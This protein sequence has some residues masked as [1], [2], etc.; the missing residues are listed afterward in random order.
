MRPLVAP[1]RLRNL[2]DAHAHKVSW[3]ELFFDLI[4]VAAVAQVA[5]PLHEHYTPDGVVRFALLFALVWWAWT[6]YAT[7]AT[8][9][10]A[11]DGLQRGLMVVQVFVVA[12]MAANAR[13]ALD[14]RSTAGFA[15]AYAVLRFILIAQYLRARR[16]VDAHTLS[17]RFAAGHGAAAVLWLV[18]AVAPM[19]S[20]FWLWGVAFIVDFGTPWMTIPA[21]VKIPPG[22]AHLPE[23]FGLFTL[24]LLGEAVVAVMRGMESQEAWPVSAAVSAVLSMVLLFSTWWWYFEGV[25]ASAARHIHSRADAVTLQLWSYAHYPLYLGVVVGGVGLRRIVT[26]AD[27]APLT[28]MDA[29]LMG[30]AAFLV[31]VSMA[32]IAATSPRP[33]PAP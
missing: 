2:A 24:I 21:H 13:E 9:F 15:A 23:R 10:D 25:D 7:F 29:T 22:A 33:R 32:A 3:L 20:R 8:R 17:T 27:R 6:G 30:A 14:S 16:I 28:I 1:L 26:A 11:D 18:S 5:D 12:A 31:G 4:F 19:P